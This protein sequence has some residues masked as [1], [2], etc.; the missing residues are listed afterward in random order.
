MSLTL[1]LR[2]ALLLAAVALPA[3]ALAEGAK[4]STADAAPAPKKGM[5]PAKKAPA[6]VVAAPAPTAPNV[7][8]MMTADE[9]YNLRMRGLEEKVGE[10]KEQI[11]R[12]KAKLQAL[13]EQVMGGGPGGATVSIV[14][15]NE[16]GPNF[17]LTE[18]QYFLD[19]AL[20]WSEVD[21]RGKSLTEK[22]LVP[23]WEG[24]IVEGSHTL[25]V[26]LV[27]KGNGT[28]VFKYM[29]GYVMRL[30]DSITFTA[31]PGK[32]VSVQAVGYE[33]GNFTTEMIERPAI[34]FDTNL[35][36]DQRPSAT[37]SQR[38]GEKAP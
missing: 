21:E 29:S 10:L 4:A 9:D 14:H 27:Y 33:S 22:R 1:H 30:K 24:N 18:A 34:R 32:V 6:P 17:L 26:S 37:D 31:E 2:A 5:K 11:F 19:G 7:D 28:G 13:T 35:A 25:T 20:V 16:M 38:T 3:A 8:G 15:K 36:V 12:S 23:V